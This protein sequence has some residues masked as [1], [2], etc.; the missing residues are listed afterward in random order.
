MT[1]L[2]SVQGLSKSFVLAGRHL[3]VLWDIDLE[4]QRGECLG[5]V[6]E[7]GSGKTTLARC[8]LQLHTL[9]AGR[10]VFD[11]QD[12]AQL[13]AAAM[14]RLRRRVQMVFQSSLDAFNPRHTVAQ[15]LAEPLQIHGV[16]GRRADRTTVQARVVELLDDVGLAADLRTRYPHQLSGGQRQR[17]GIARALATAPQL[18]VLDEPVSALDVSVRAQILTLLAGLRQRY[19]LTLVFISHDL[20]TVAQVADRI[21]VLYAGRLVEV[22]DAARLTRHPQHPY[23]RDLFAAAPWVEL[24]ARDRS[25]RSSSAATAQSVEIPPSGNG[26]PYSGRC[27]L[28][29]LPHVDANPCRT[30]RP[31]LR[32]VDGGRVACHHPLEAGQGILSAEDASSTGDRELASQVRINKR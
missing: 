16:E 31:E 20:P 24:A 6:G 28:V 2:L 7:S 25:K 32:D 26:C 1:A 12:L 3:P 9:D 29:S 23:T 27:G 30:Q 11:G 18:V 8:A 19:G 5:L 13:P 15:A 21:A 17:L 14:R 10:V 4:V 22:G